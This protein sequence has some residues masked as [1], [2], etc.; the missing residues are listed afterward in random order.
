MD[1]SS[2]PR[3]AVRL[4]ISKMTVSLFMVSLHCWLRKRLAALQTGLS[5]VRIR[6]RLAGHALRSAFTERVGHA[7]D[8]TDTLADLVRALICALSRGRATAGKQQS[9]RGY[10]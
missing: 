8:A 1:G 9:N 4:S 5:S 10:C 3:A 2:A 7:A 6:V